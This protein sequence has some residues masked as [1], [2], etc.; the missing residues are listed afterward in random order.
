MTSV[1]LLRAQAVAPL[2]AG[3]AELYDRDASFPTADVEDLRSQGLLGLMVPTRLGGLG[4]GFGDYTEVAIELGK[5]SGATALLFNMHAS[6]TGALAGMRDEVARSLGAPEEFFTERDRVLAA[7]ASGAMYGVAISEAA[8][9]SRL[10]RLQ[11][12]YR[13]DGE[14]FR[15]TG[16]KVACSGAGYLDGYLVAARREDTPEQ[17]PVISYLL[18]PG[19]AVTVEGGW[20]PLGMRATASRGLILDTWVPAEALVGGIEGLAVPLAYLMPQWLVASYAAVYIGVAEGALAA[21][22]E[23][24]HDRSRLGPAVRGRLGR[25]DADLEAARLVVQRAAQLIDGQP[26]HPETNRWVYRAKL[27]AG[28]VVMSVAASIAEACGLSALTRGSPI[29]RGFRD[30]RLGAVMPP[31]SDVCA[32]YLGATLLGLDPQSDLDEAPW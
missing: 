26:G 18:V 21:A 6:V 13:P 17:M 14:G 3:R 24:L 25:A 23:L 10:S 20:D 27:L 4:S 29:E 9:G 5:A 28:D 19:G 12:S 30:A 22:K 31:R 1:G 15:I 16:T 8:A 11:T 7:A 2:L 32:D